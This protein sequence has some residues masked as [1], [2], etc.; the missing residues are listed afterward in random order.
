MKITV[1]NFMGMMPRFHPRLLPDTHAQIARNTRLENGA[2]TSF[3]VETAEHDFGTPVQTMYLDGAS[4]VGWDAVVHVVPAPI[5]EDRIYITGDGVP[6]MEVSG[7]SYNLALPAPAQ[8]PVLS[9]TSGTLD[10]DLTEDIIYAYT[11]VTGFGEESQP[12]PLSDPIQWSAGM[13]IN[14]DNFSAPIGGRNITKYRIYRSQTSVAGATTLFFVAEINAPATDYDHDMVTN[15]IID[16]I[17]TFDYDPPPDTMEGIITLPNGMMAAF[18]GKELLFCEP[19]L[20]HAWPAKYTLVSDY[21]IVGLAAFG[22]TIAV[23][24]KGTPYVVQG[25]TPDSMAMQKTEEPLAC[26]SGPGLV[27]MGYSAI[28]PSPDGLVSISPAGTSVITK[29]LWTKEQWE[30]QGPETI[31]AGR[32]GGRY[33]FSCLPVGAATRKTYILD[34]SGDQPY[35]L[36]SDTIIQQFY[37]DIR[38]GKLFILIGSAAVY[39]WDSSAANRDTF[40]WRSKVWE[41]P[42]EVSFGAIRVEGETFASG[43]TDSLTIRVYADG[44]L[45]ANNAALNTT[46][47]IAA[48]RAKRWEVE[49]EGDVSVS[50]L[51]LAGTVEEV[52]LG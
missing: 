17:T 42:G 14:L 24:T 16:P 12:S 38:T 43:S 36:E 4:W 47:R 8:E 10:P 33:V 5:A 28:F 41:I 48:V 40:V 6:K 34:V 50:A 2:I 11:Y 22:S 31:V 39:E 18:D 49:L 37:H 7:T 15:P 26:V 13:V 27:D 21:E 52:A 29:N 9:V 45:V 23:V 51:I 20:P 3:R 25:L 46:G 35:L 1:G 32:Y 44:V 19:Y 30:A